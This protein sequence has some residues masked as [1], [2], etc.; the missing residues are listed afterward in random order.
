MESNNTPVFAS[1]FS[2]ASPGFPACFSESFKMFVTLGQGKDVL[3][4][5]VIGEQ[6]E[7]LTV[8]SELDSCIPRK[9]HLD[10][11]SQE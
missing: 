3:K 11:S 9:K 7:M 2:Y 4:P 1:N 10:E 6:I 8:K 5:G